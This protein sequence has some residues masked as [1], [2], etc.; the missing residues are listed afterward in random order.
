MK[1]RSTTT[2]NKGAVII[3]RNNNDGKR[4]LKL[5]TG[6]EVKMEC[7]LSARRAF[8][9]VEY[10]V[11]KVRNIYLFSLKIKRKGVLGFWGFG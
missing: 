3:I 7:P 4:K 11:H 2:S 8:D 10:Y 9:R 6:P 1:E 5:Y